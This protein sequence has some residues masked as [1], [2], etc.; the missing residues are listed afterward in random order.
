MQLVRVGVRRLHVKSYGMRL[1]L[2][3]SIPASRYS[4]GVAPRRISTNNGSQTCRQLFNVGERECRFVPNRWSAPGVGATNILPTFVVDRCTQR[5]AVV[6]NLPS[7]SMIWLSWT[8]VMLTWPVSPTSSLLRSRLTTRAYRGLK[9]RR[10]EP[11]TLPV[12]DI[13]TENAGVSLC[14]AREGSPLTTSHDA[15]AICR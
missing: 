13:F 15:A 9:T 11:T 2:R 6:Y 14:F 1:A 10:R 4:K 3:P 7:L 8:F 5:H 12:Q